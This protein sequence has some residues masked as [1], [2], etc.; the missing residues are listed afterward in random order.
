MNT[1]AIILIIGSIVI[2]VGAASRLP[3]ALAELVRACIPL[4]HAVKE[5]RDALRRDDP[6]PSETAERDQNGRREE[7]IREFEPRAAENVEAPIADQDS[8]ES[9]ATAPLTE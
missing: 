2:I 5:L 1:T 3:G 8:M 7:H 4:V 6:A 9:D